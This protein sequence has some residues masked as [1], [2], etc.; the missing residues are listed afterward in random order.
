MSTAKTVKLAAPPKRPPAVTI[1]YRNRIERFIKE[2][3][4]NSAAIFVSL[5]EQ[6]RSR[7]TSFPYRQSS[8][9]YYLNG[10]PEPE[11][12]L[13]LSNFK[14]KNKVTM[15]LL[16]KDEERERWE[17][18]RVGL[19]G[20]LQN[21]HAD[22]AL[23]IKEFESVITE[24]LAQASRVYYRLGINTEFDHVFLKQLSKRQRPLYNP[25]DILHEQRLFKSAEEITLM[26][27]AADIS[28]LAHCQAMRVCRPGM[29]ECELK[30]EVEHIFT[31]YG[32]NFPAYGSIVAAGNNANVLHYTWNNATIN[33]EDLILIDAGC[34]FGGISGGYAADITRT[35]PANG[36]FS[37][38]QRH[39]Y[40]LVLDAQ[41]KAIGAVKPGVPLSKIHDI[42]NKVL[43]E[44]LIELG[45]LPKNAKLN[46]EETGKSKKGKDKNGKNKLCLF[47]FY[48]HGTS[49]WLGI[50]VHD[51]GR[52]NTED[53]TRSD[54]GRGKRRLLE[55]GMVFTVEPGLYF[56]KDDKRIPKEYRGIA[57]RIEDDVEVTKDGCKVLTAG[58]PKSVEG[59]EALMRSGKDSDNGSSR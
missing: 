56:R 28:A 41:M 10:F 11:S 57:I 24:T 3:P 20:A 49:H 14:G 44:G 29:N 48:M 21:Y 30:A 17:G 52:Y 35:F 5:P 2:M 51:V 22:E 42:A 32:A 33:D 7:D 6:T 19:A 16:P 25:D 18:I 59:I 34:E 54:R 50:D 39:I 36:K 15:L 13:I 27:H 26:K 58:V 23:E 47:D 31:S 55:A 37:E 43:L 4:E 8:D 46:N 45:I 40:Q 53:G 1:P 12:A 9:I 38:P